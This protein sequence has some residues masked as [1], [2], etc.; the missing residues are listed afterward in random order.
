MQVLI[1]DDDP[2]I[3]DSALRYLLARS[4]EVTIT[5]TPDKALDLIHHTVFDCILLDVSTSAK[6][7]RLLEI[8]QLVRASAVAFMCTMPI[9]SLVAEAI[10]EGS[11]ECQAFPLLIDRLEQF[12]QPTMLAGANLPAE[13]LQSARNKSLRI[14][15]ARTLQF[16]MNLLVDG[17]CQI[18]WLDAEIPG[19]SHPGKGAIVHKVE[20][21]QLA[22]L[23]SAVSDSTPAITCRPKPE[24]A[25]ELVALLQHI[26]GNQPAPCGLA[27]VRGKLDSNVR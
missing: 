2:S 14:C 27:E 21:K 17:W 20:T 3:D 11:I 5:G 18:V 4:Y 15:T 25:A 1:F 10:A 12:D 8:R 22:I 6:C 9:E 16:A 13:L 24:K 26:A 19:H 23:A 7:L